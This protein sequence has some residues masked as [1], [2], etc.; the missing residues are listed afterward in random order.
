MH[1]SARAVNPSA[2]SHGRV[3][4]RDPAIENVPC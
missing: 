2:P 4:A 1:G 3:P